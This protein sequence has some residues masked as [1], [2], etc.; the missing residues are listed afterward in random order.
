LL[1]KPNYA[2]LFEDDFEDEEDKLSKVC[3]YYGSRCIVFCLPQRMGTKGKQFCKIIVIVQ[4]SYRRFLSGEKD[5][6]PGAILQE[7]I[8]RQFS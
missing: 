8:I 5:N 3:K 2:Q 6:S 7:T 1:P 4:D